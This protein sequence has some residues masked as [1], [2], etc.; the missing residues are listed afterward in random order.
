MNKKYVCVKI[1]YEKP[2]QAAN[3]VLNDGN[4]LATVL[5]Y[6]SDV[7]KGG[8]TVFPTLNL[9]LWPEKG[10]AVFWF[11][12]KRNGEGDMRTQHAACPVLVGS[13]WGK[14]NH[15]YLNQFGTY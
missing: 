13:K 14:F 9:T 8:A 6:M 7:E 4:R 11:N 5:F 1:I 10:S 2:G 12:L 15:S 3:F